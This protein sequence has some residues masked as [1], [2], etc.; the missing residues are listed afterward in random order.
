[1]RFII[2]IQVA[3]ISISIIQFFYIFGKL[4]TNQPFIRCYDNCYSS[5]HLQ[6]NVTR[7]AVKD[8]TKLDL[9]SALLFI[10]IKI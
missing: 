4:R 9:D 7:I 1:M 10:F 5:F 3:E 8:E 2:F 6:R